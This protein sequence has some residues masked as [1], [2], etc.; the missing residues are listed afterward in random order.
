MQNKSILFSLGRYNIEKNHI[1]VLAILLLSFTISFLI[2]I[3]PGQYGW[4]LN[5]FDP[6]FNFRATQYFVENGLIEY[7]NWHDELSWYP[8]GRDVSLNSQTILHITTGI[9]YWI[10]GNNSDL[11]QFTVLFPVI[12]GSLTCF[13]IFGLVRRI[14]GTTAGLIASVLFSTSLPIL[15]RGQLGWFKSEPLGLFFGIFL[16]F[17]FLSSLTGQNKILRLIKLGFSGILLAFTLSA[18]GGG[19]FFVF[20]I[21]I[22]IIYLSYSKN[23]IKFLSIGIPFFIICSFV[24]CILFQR[25]GIDFILG[26]GGLSIILPTFLMLVSF[27]ISKRSKINRIRNISIFISLVILTL[28]SF[29]IFNSENS[30]VFSP[31]HRYLNAII[32]TLTTSD[33]L[34]DSVSEHQITSLSQS[35]QFHSIYM[36]FA[37]IGIWLLFQKKSSQHISNQMKVFSL[38]LGLFAVYLSAGFMRLEVFA[39][40]AMVILSSIGISI[41]FRE[42]TLKR[43]HEP[44]ISKYIKIVGLSVIVILI[45]VPIILPTNYSATAILSNSPPTIL[46][47]GTN[48][49]FSSN[50]W[51]ETLEW[52]KNN[53]PNDAVIA[54][55]WD[56]G[57]W[58]QT[59]GERASLADNSTLNDHIIKNIAKILF[60][61]PDEAWKSLRDMESDY[62][63]LFVAGERLYGQNPDTLPLYILGGGGDESKIYWFSKIAGYSPES[64]MYMDNFAFKDNF[65]NQTFLGKI[66]PYEQIGFINF[67][68]QRFSTEYMP[69]WTP[70]FTKNSL[71]LTNPDGPF[72]LVYSSSSYN[73]N[74]PG[75]LISVFVYKINED[76]IIEN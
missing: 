5:E 34:T 67:E 22:F 18:W 20:V 24:S 36:V 28:T 31:S 56:Y 53:T 11:Y 72:I 10:F 29:V 33:P 23:D 51:L 63:V 26:V 64:F 76:Y 13:V 61:S 47:G 71:D 25:P 14:A 50:D 59:I 74:E 57:Y 70:A 19:M 44:R 1:L 30:I 8:H 15:V 21:G 45:C 37:G 52:I 9:S 17:M 41:L 68:S 55:W 48:F 12:I 60:E 2:R 62:F 4:E 75:P 3:L 39:G 7:L 46:N 32:P 58:I 69:G 49:S 38:I 43:D 27:F 54:S 35:F 65:T 16:L 40:L 66:F 6:F 42:L 73:H